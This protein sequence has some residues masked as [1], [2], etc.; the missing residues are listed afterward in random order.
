MHAEEM[1]DMIVEIVEL[2][3]QPGSEAAFVDGV[4]R[5]SDLFATSKGCRSM[6]LHRCL[7]EENTFFLYVEWDSVDDHMVGFRNSPA[8]TRWRELVG[9]HFAAPPKVRHSEQVLRNF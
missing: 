2:S 7:E 3:I 6:A 8:F 1:P 4:R 5:A 9:P